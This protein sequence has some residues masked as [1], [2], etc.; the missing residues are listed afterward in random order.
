VFKCNR[1]IYAARFQKY[2][3][4]CLFYHRLSGNSLV[5]NKTMRLRLLLVAL[6]IIFCLFLLR[7]VVFPDPDFGW[8]I[9]E[10]AYIL[11]NGIPYTDHFSY[12][13]P[14]Y[15]FVDH[16]WLTNIV[17]F[18]IFTFWG[19]TPLLVISS[20]LAVGSLLVLYFFSDRKWAFMPFVIGGVTFFDFFGV[21]TQIITWFF[22]SLLMIVL[23]K[24]NIWDKWR[25]GLP[26]LFLLWANLHGGFGIGLGVLG[27]VLLGRILEER[28][29]IKER[30]FLLILCAGASLINP[31]GIRLWWEF[32]MQLTDTQLRWSVTEWYPA[33]YFT[34]I[35]FWGYCL[36]SVFLVLVY[37]KKYTWTEL[38]LY[39]FLLF[40]GFSSMRNLPIWIIASFFPTVR[41]FS[42]LAKESA[43][44]TGGMKRFLISYSVY[45]GILIFIFFSQSGMFF[46]GVFIEN[47]NPAPY[48]V[49]AVSYLRE[50]TPKG[51]IFSSYDWG[52]YLDWKLPQKKVF[53][54]GR[55]PSWRW[56]ANIKGESNYAFSDYKKVL[57]GDIPFSSFA[58]EYHISTILVPRSAAV[59]PTQKIFGIIINN[60]FIL[61]K[62]FFSWNSFYGVVEQVKHMGWKEVYHD[63]TAEIYEKLQ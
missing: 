47:E 11:H 51:N 6:F 50:H 1:K 62:L 44:Y 38:F 8:H 63:G 4:H 41:G 42:L 48:P 26:L 19:S 27:I 17:W 37:R 5:Y 15:P 13:M 43:R 34:N 28:R 30:L 35:A 2:L 59:K 23:F 16:E 31:Y 60:N 20:L 33:F 24:K 58:K 45:S 21:R 49:Q 39:F 32:F 52:G 12:S 55:M 36:L 29:K 54:D 61:N 3:F 9:R 25:F 46:Y 22:L 57:T 14:G 7:G 53:I 56:D 40:E 18:E 10:G